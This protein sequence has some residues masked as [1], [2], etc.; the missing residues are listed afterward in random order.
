M[1]QRHLKRF[2]CAPCFSFLAGIVLLLSLSNFM[3]S[4]SW[5]GAGASPQAVNNRAKIKVKIKK[6]TV[7]KHVVSGQAAANKPPRIKIKKKVKI[8]KIRP[9]V[10]NWV[11]GVGGAEGQW[12]KGTYLK[13]RNMDPRAFKAGERSTYLSRA[14]LESKRL[15]VVDVP[16]KKK[17]QALRSKKFEK[18]LINS[19]GKPMNIES[20]T[21]F[22]VMGLDGKL[23]V[24]TSRIKDGFFHSSFFSGRPVASA[25]HIIIK[26]GLVT[27]IDNSSGHYKP[28]AE[29]LINA[30]EN[31]RLQGVINTKVFRIAAQ[32]NLPPEMLLKI[33]DYQNK[34]F[35]R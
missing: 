19:D 17:L 3:T 32:G 27:Q 28:T 18:K 12:V 25:G 35:P 26:D 31:L 11:P 7:R 34:T 22:Y 20:D 4:V 10:V 21:G 1:P 2:R 8:T 24:N 23:Y 30:V 29:H 6:E 33:A 13:G 16:V 5:A 9:T 14:Q 15:R